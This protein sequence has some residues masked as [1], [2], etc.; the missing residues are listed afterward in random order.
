MKFT[1]LFFFC[2]INLSCNSQKDYFFVENYLKNSNQDLTHTFL[3]TKN[4]DYNEVL[5]FY[6]E[7]ESFL[8]KNN[9]KSELEKW[10]FTKEE[11][12]QIQDFYSEKTMK[13]W[14]DK[15]LSFLKRVKLDTLKGKSMYTFFHTNKNKIV[16]VSKPLYNIDKNK[17]MFFYSFTNG[18]TGN[19]QNYLV[20]FLKENDVWEEVGKIY[21]GNLH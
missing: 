1:R 21:S 8:V 2:L 19:S 7:R 5:N 15:Q 4:H 9:S 16:S 10:I 17:C 14:E 3:D 20:T 12:K 18:P 13:P 11:L 6:I